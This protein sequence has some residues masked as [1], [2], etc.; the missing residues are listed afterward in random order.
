MAKR[1]TE[2]QKIAIIQNFIEGNTID[3][4]SNQFECTKL[5]IIRNLKKNLGESRYQELIH[6]NR[7]TNND[8]HEN[9]KGNQNFN[10]EL[11]DAR[12]KED[13]INNK[14]LNENQNEDDYFSSSFL[15]ITPLDYE[16]EEKSRKELSSIP[17]SDIDFP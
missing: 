12:S 9:N 2:K 6:K 7:T 3:F 8:F 14:S 15:E 4:L 1:L 11:N 17:I 10:Y 5:T 13:T 16:I